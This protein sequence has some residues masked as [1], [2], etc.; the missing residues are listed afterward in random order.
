MNIRVV[1]SGCATCERL[2]KQV[3]RI[4]EA[5]GI[6]AQVEYSTDV[7]ELIGAGVMGSPGLFIDG[8]VAHVGS[9]DDEGLIELLEA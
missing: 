5:N 2:H 9:I 8:H 1:G 7:N 4:V 3:L 6:D